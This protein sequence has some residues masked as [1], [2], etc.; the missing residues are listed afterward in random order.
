MHA[1]ASYKYKLD[2]C[3]APSHATTNDSDDDVV[4]VVDDAAADDEDDEDGD[5]DDDDENDD[6]DDVC[7]QPLFGRT[8]S[9]ELSGTKSCQTW[10]TTRF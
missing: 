10:R 3:V 6:D 9:Q 7:W 2:N 1:T 4:D 5:D 8:L